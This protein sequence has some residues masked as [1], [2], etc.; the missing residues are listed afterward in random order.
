[1]IIPCSHCGKKLEVD[2]SMSGRSARCPSCHQVFTIQLPAAGAPDVAEPAA[3]APAKA[4]PEV[5]IASPAGGMLASLLGPWPASCG[6]VTL[7]ARVLLLAGLVLV[8]LSRGCDSIGNRAVLRASAKQQHVENE[9]RDKWDRQIN[10][11][12]PSE[13]SGLRE[14]MSK[15]RAELEKDDWA[16]LKSAA[17][18]ASS[19]NAMWGYWREW[20]F[21]AGTIVL[22]LGLVGTAFTS[23]V[24]VERILCLL[25]MAII[26]FSIYIGG[27]A[28]IGS[29][30]S[31]I[32]RG[33]P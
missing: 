20:M 19:S 25:M 24:L 15:E 16:E 22:V 1:M 32:P 30:A 11:A 12:N 4:E 13:M 3:S 23:G 27:L 10:A 2:E 14:K 6:R 17:R 31:N 18:D 26:T 29:I 9:F 8:L 21:L 5:P 28:W 33:L 7:V